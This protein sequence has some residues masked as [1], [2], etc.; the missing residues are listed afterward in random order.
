MRIHPQ[1]PTRIALLTLLFACLCLM[2]LRS[3]EASICVYWKAYLLDESGVLDLEHNDYTD[4]MSVYVTKQPY[5]AHIIIAAGDNIDFTDAS[6]SAYTPEGRV[7]D[8]EDSISLDV[9][10]QELIVTLSHPGVEV[11]LELDLDYDIGDSTDGITI[12]I[13]IGDDDDPC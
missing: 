4:A 8:V 11:E 13:V 9:D 10:A 2:P 12:P 3:S 6:I 5:E 1:A 7:Y